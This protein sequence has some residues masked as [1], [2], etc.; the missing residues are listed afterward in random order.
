MAWEMARC[1]STEKHFLH[2]PTQGIRC[3]TIAYRLELGKLPLSL[4]GEL[5]HLQLPAPPSSSKIA[6]LYNDAL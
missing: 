4:N 1:R 3:L 5:S 6:A 2:P